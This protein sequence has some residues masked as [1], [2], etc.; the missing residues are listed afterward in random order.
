MW[1]VVIQVRD[2]NLMHQKREWRVSEVVFQQ[3]REE[4]YKNLKKGADEK[5]KQLHAN[6]GRCFCITENLSSE[7]FI[8]PGNQ[9]AES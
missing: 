5:V 8:F 2:D 4:G 3:V 6:A 7:Y 1:M 9:V